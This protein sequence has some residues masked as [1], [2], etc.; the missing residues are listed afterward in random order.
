MNDLKNTPLRAAR[1]SSG[2]L[3]IALSTVISSAVY[4]PTVLAHSEQHQ[5]PEQVSSAILADGHAPIGVMGDH[6]HKT[7]EWMVGYRYMQMDMEG[8]IRGNDSLSPQQVAMQESVMMV[9]LEMETNMHMLGIMYAPTDDV[10]LAVASSYLD[11]K[12]K[13]IMPMGMGMTSETRSSG[14]GDIK[15]NA[16]FALGDTASAT[17][18]QRWHANLGLSVPTGSIDEEANMGRKGYGMQLGTG[19]YDAKLGIS[20]AGFESRLGWGGQASTLVALNEN[21]HDYKRKPSYMATAWASY[22]FVPSLSTSLRIKH[23]HKGAVSGQDAG[24]TMS[25]TGTDTKNTGRDITSLGLGANFV[26]SHGIM[27][28]HR[29][30]IEWLKPLHQ[31]VRGVQ[32]EMQDMMTLGYQYAF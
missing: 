29:F 3:S 15:I 25:M 16:L 24:M 32:L 12:M 18:S 21:K 2:A 9:P 8:N 1:L 26:S 13:T 22:R 27:R 4:S 14:V 23:E 7:G 6:M 10:T 5:P 20:Y 19:T 11:K 17:G 28:G 30:A 31:D